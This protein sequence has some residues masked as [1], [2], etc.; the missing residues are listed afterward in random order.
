MSQKTENVVNDRVRRTVRRSS[1]YKSKLSEAS[2]L[3]AQKMD[4]KRKEWDS[5]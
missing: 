1:E 3:L 5:K 2:V 4:E